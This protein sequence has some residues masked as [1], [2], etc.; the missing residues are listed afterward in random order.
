MKSTKRSIS[1]EVGWGRHRPVCAPAKAAVTT[2][3]E[4]AGAQAQR[5]GWHAGQHPHRNVF[6]RPRPRNPQRINS[7]KH[8]L[9][10]SKTSKTLKTAGRRLR[11][12]LDE[13]CETEGAEPLVTELCKIADRLAEVRAQI[14]KDGVAPAGKKNPLLDIEIKLSGMFTKTWRTLG[15]A[16]K[17]PEVRRPVGRPPNSER[18]CA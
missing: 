4:A 15:L 10:N 6:R 5:E 2:P 8:M 3:P 13:Q 7:P 18:E 17:E 11:Q 9:K 1:L 14:A 12:W 16:D